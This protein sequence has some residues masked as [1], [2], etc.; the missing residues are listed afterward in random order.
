MR[1]LIVSLLICLVFVLCVPVLASAETLEYYE[2]EAR[3]KKDFSV[4]H[5]ITLIFNSSVSHFDYSIGLEIYDL[6]VSNKYGTADCKVAEGLRGSIISCD[7]YNQPDQNKSHF[8][9]NFS[10]KDSVSKLDGIYKFKADYGISQAIDRAFIAIYLPETALLATNVPNESFYP[11]TGNTISDGRHI[12][13]YWER[14]DV[15]PDD[16]LGSEVSYVIEGPKNPFYEYIII[17][18]AII[19][20]IGMVI[21]G[22]Y[23][24][25]ISKK[26]KLETIMPLLKED[27][28]KI[29]KI[30]SLH[31][32][33]AIQKVLVRESEFSK[34]RVSR[35]VKNLKDRGIINVE[36]MGRTNK[37]TLK[38]KHLK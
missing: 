3:I 26:Q 15:K 14:T 9:F 8:T 22:F 27:E 33:E 2:V 11:K 7:F 29:V 24:K 10:S 17:S 19:I 25:V 18:L 20:I 21:L 37:I 12:I 4:S 38:V 34:A 16:V 23:F 31:K 1:R 5:L 6:N 30:L 32:G 13:V 28:K 35:L 36:P